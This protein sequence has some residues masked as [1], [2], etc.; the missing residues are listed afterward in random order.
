ME[1]IRWSEKNHLWRA[2]DRGQMHRRR[3]NRGDKPRFPYERR[4][5][6]QI[7]FAGKIDDRSCRELAFD[8]RD[9]ALLDFGTSTRQ[10]RIKI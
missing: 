10:H 3:I 8:F 7:G 6:E 5:N 1:W 9:V 4:Q 2:H